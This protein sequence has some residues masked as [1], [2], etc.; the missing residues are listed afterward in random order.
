MKG[1][2]RTVYL[3]RGVFLL[4]LGVMMLVHPGFAALTLVALVLVF[5][6][7]AIAD[8]VMGIVGALR[9]D[10]P[11][12]GWALF[13][14]ILGIA[15]GSLLLFA[16]SFAARAVYAFI[17]TWAIL[18]GITKLM[19]AGKVGRGAKRALQLH[20]ALTIAFGV[21]MIALPTSWVIASVGRFI[22]IWALLASGAWLALGLGF[23]RRGAQA[24]PTAPEEAPAT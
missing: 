24:R 20:G 9:R 1:T 4:L 10:N 16:P 17:A 19:L 11:A 18:T 6:V 12:R 13:D 5:A 14:G 7:Y 22:A 15:T 2:T 8:G 21:L 3:I 23:P